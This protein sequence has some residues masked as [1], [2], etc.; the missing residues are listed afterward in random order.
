MGFW[1]KASRA[2]GDSDSQAAASGDATQES[3][4][5]Q[6]VLVMTPQPLNNAQQLLQ[7]IA[8][9]QTRNGHAIASGFIATTRVGDPQDQA[10]VYAAIRSAFESFGG[11]DV[12][13]RTTVKTF[14]ASDGNAGS[15]FVLF[16]RP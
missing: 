8:D 6:A 14:Q 2:G 4:K 16:D 9:E 15:Y 12:I 10:Y 11:E 7:Q 1:R 3:K 5:V 13:E